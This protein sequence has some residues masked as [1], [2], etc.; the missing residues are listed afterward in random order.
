MTPAPLPKFGDVI[1]HGGHRWECE[2]TGGNCTAWMRPAENA[3]P[4]AR[5]L[6]TE[7]G[8]ACAPNPKARGPV[9]L[10]LEDPD[11]NLWLGA[12]CSS[13]AVAARLAARFGGAA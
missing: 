3:A 12:E 5:W 11:G 1:F 7:A 8:E 10:S 13:F 2:S 6:I 4:C 9:M